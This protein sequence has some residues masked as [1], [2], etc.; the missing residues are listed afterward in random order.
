MSV[1][2]RLSDKKRS[3]EDVNLPEPNFGVAEGVTTLDGLDFRGC[4]IVVRFGETLAC[5]DGAYESRR[6][7][8]LGV[9]SK[10]GGVTRGMGAVIGCRCW[11]C[12]CDGCI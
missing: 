11:C 6:R 1:A 12:C 9:A 2:F 3:S 7:V 4:V 5:L 10:R 8:L